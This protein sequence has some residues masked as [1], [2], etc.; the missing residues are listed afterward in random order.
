MFVY[1]HGPMCAWCPQG[2]KRVS[3]PLEPESL[4]VVS[5]LVGAGKNLGPL[6]EQPVI[7]C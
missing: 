2:Q 5:H 3:D 1:V 7:L 4:A 6:G